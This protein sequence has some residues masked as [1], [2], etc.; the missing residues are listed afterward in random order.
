MVDEIKNVISFGKTNIK[1]FF[2]STTA[3][4]TTVKTPK[5]TKVYVISDGYYGDKWAKAED[6]EFKKKYPKATII[7]SSDNRYNC[8]SY[9]WYNQ[10][11]NNRYW[12]NDPR[13]Y[14]TD[15]SYAKITNSKK[16]GAN[17]RIC[18]EL[19]ALKQPIV[20]SGILKK[21]NSDGSYTVYSN[22]EKAH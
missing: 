10:G 20:H 14:V 22:G 5:G 3:L 12:M 1:N 13:A 21:I 7:R 19:Y 17:N 9:A 8:H 11:T 6:A 18:W 4:T 16:R 2:V 15:G